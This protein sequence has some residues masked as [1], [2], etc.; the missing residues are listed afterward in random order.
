MM[1]S[2]SPH[3][4]SVGAVERAVV[5]RNRRYLFVIGK[6]GGRLLDTRDGLVLSGT[7]VPPGAM[8]GR[9]EMAQCFNQAFVSDTGAIEL[10]CGDKEYR[11]ESVAFS[12]D[13]RS[14]LREILTNQ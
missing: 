11:R 10:V 14:R 6:S 13:A 9:V 4:S 2:P 7:L 12:G 8:E 3:I 5:S 1:R